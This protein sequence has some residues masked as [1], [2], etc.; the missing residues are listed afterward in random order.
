V[1]NFSAQLI[2][3]PLHHQTAH[4]FNEI[5]PEEKQIQVLKSTKLTPT[6]Q[7]NE[8]ILISLK[9]WIDQNQQQ[10]TQEKN[11]SYTFISFN[12]IEIMDRSK[13]YTINSRKKMNLILSSLLISSKLWIDQNSIHSSSDCTSTT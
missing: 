3:S 1:C 12:L 8:Y 11:E 13:Q 2:H 6:V 5:N 7:K 4:N 10:T 9:L